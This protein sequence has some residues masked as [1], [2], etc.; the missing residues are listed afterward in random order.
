MQNGDEKKQKLKRKPLSIVLS[1]PCMNRVYYI[2][3]TRWA[4]N[5]CTYISYVAGTFIAHNMRE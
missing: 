2:N 1:D 3:N 4:R 5:A